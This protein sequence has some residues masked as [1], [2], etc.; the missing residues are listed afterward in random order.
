M[1]FDCIPVPLP[2]AVKRCP[3]P[4][5]LGQSRSD[6][7]TFASIQQQFPQLKLLRFIESPHQ[8][9][10]LPKSFLSIWSRFP[11]SFNQSITLNRETERP[12]RQFAPAAVRYL[13]EQFSLHLAQCARFLPSV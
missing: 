12:P 4:P 5:L 13:A 6:I 8:E 10:S 2:P 7:P 1:N 3:S 11:V 9:S